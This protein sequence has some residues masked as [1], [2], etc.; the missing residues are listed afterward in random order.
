[1]KVLRWDITVWWKPSLIWCRLAFWEE[2]VFLAWFPYWLL[3]AFWY[4]LFSLFSP[5]G[6]TLTTPQASEDPLKSKSPIL[7]SHGSTQHFVVFASENTGPAWRNYPQHSLASDGGGGYH[8]PFFPPNSLLSSLSFLSFWSHHQIFPS[9]Y[10]WRLPE[11]ILGNGW[12]KKTFEK[13]R[14]SKLSPLI[15]AIVPVGEKEES[16]RARALLVMKNAMQE[17]ASL[18]SRPV[19]PTM[20][21]TTDTA[22]VHQAFLCCCTTMSVWPRGLIWNWGTTPCLYYTSAGHQ[23]I[24]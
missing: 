4:L 6:P 8:S 23:I 21:S 7:M 12:L 19:K 9:F 2:T 1:M 14:L 20:Y 3:T 15:K 11:S 16:R 22:L 5:T 10:E 18:W 17:G 13:M 24:S